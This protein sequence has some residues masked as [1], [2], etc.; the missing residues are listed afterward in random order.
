MIDVPKLFFDWLSEQARS[1]LIG[2]V[3]ILMFILN[4]IITGINKSLHV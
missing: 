4:Y 2:Y 1:N 3:K